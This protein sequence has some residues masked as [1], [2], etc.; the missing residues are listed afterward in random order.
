MTWYFWAVSAMYRAG[1]NQPMKLIDWTHMCGKQVDC[2]FNIG[3]KS[4][5]LGID[6]TNL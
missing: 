4:T 1:S 2:S 6:R 3:C 5:Y